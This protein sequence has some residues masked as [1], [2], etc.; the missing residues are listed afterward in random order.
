MKKALLI[1]IVIFI[2]VISLTSCAAGTANGK[3]AEGWP[4]DIPSCLPAFTYGVYQSDQLT[5][6]ESGGIITYMMRFTGVSKDDV[7]A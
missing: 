7:K 5:R 4:N 3:T 6:I 2:L 1:I